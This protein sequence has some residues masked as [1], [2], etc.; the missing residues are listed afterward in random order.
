MK[1]KCRALLG[2]WITFTLAGVLPCQA[3]YVHTRPNLPGLVKWVDPEY[4]AAL[5]HRGISGRGVFLL[6]IDSKTGEVVEVKVIKSTGY[7]VLNE[8]AAKG[9]LQCRFQPGGRTEIKIP[10]E[11]WAHGFAR[12]VH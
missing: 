11:F 6:K 9:F 10:Y 2:L 12:Q 3:D 7:T 4:P 5:R 8:L 1:P